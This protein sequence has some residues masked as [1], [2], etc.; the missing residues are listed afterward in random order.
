MGGNDDR[1]LGRPG[2]RRRAAMAT[3]TYPPAGARAM[4]VVAAA[5]A[6]RDR[7]RW[8]LPDLTRQG[9]VGARRHGRSARSA[10]GLGRALR[11]RR[12]GLPAREA[13]AALRPRTGAPAN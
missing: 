11:L 10:R 3:G 9:L 7:A 13:S 8:A 1:L 5:V 6:R 12:M 4:A 2:T